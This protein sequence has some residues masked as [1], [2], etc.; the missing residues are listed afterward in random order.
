MYIEENIK[1]ILYLPNGGENGGEIEFTDHE[2]IDNSVSISSQCMSDTS[3]ALGGVYSAQLSMVIRLKS[4]GLSSYNVIGSKV[5]IYTKYDNEESYILRG[6]FWITSASRYKDIYTLSGSDMITWLDTGTYNSSET[7]RNYV[8]NYLQSQGSDTLSTCMGNICEAVNDILVSSKTERIFFEWNHETTINNNPKEDNGIYPGFSLP[9]TEKTG[10]NDTK[11]PR[12]YASWIAAA[13][14][15][16]I[17]VTNN[18]LDNGSPMLYNGSPVDCAIKIGQFETL[19]TAEIAYNFIENDSLDIADFKVQKYNACFDLSFIEEDGNETRRY[20]NWGTS[21]ADLTV[22]F[23]DNPFVQ[24]YFFN[25]DYNCMKILGN[26]YSRLKEITIRPF[27]LKCHCRERFRLGQCVNIENE[28]GEKCNSI[29]TKMNWSFRSGYEL[30]CAG[31]DNRILCDTVRRTPSAKAKEQAVT[32]LNYE[33]T[34]LVNKITKVNS[35]LQNQINSSAQNN[36]E[37]FDNLQSQIDDIYNKIDIMHDE[38]TEGSLYWHICKLR[39]R[40]ENL[41]NE[42]KV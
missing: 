5:K 35:N 23:S 6:V 42:S 33:K 9:G 16:F 27:S 21:N 19:P 26:V 11:D 3:F 20:G 36:S 24:A 31:E 34:K 14:C 40:I 28:K 22:D 37:N 18:P 17:D 12:D 39:E 30:A 2:I 29:I 8:Y 38:N 4:D 32:K 10:E 1:G 41:E 7:V 15:G 25:N 13:A